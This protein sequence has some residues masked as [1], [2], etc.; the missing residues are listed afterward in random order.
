MPKRRNKTVLQKY[1]GKVRRKG[2][3]VRKWI[4]DNP[5]H[6]GLTASSVLAPMAAYRVTE[7]A[8]DLR[9]QVK[10]IGWDA[11]DKNFKTP[12]GREF[13][14]QYISDKYGRVRAGTPFEGVKNALRSFKLGFPSMR[15]QPLFSS[16]KRLPSR[17]MHMISSMKPAVRKAQIR[18]LKT[19][20]RR[21]LPLAVGSLLAAPIG[22]A[23]KAQYKKRRKF[24]QKL[25]K[26]MKRAI[27]DPAKAVALGLGPEAILQK[28]K[29]GYVMPPVQKYMGR[30]Y[31]RYGA[32]KQYW[33]G[34]TSSPHSPFDRGNR[35]L[36]YEYYD[37]TN[38][39][40]R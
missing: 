25:R 4:K 37:R 32:G 13:A 31:G 5:H 20:S 16:I 28:Y 35:G 30:Q 14:R 18:F 34:R 24:R 36:E 7:G 29:I 27:K 23:M 33:Q 39:R 8:R 19:A 40:K 9:R 10:K 15:R 17:E 3:K 38:R 26:E 11:I 6:I 1:T 21:A 12:R 2:R 22:F